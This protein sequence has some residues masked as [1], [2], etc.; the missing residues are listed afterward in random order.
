M[1]TV[2]VLFENSLNKGIITDDV[3]KIFGRAIRDA[4]QKNGLEITNEYVGLRKDGNKMYL[5]IYT[6]NHESINKLLPL[7]EMFFNFHKKSD[8]TIKNSSEVFKRRIGQILFRMYEIGRLKKENGKVVTL[9]QG[10]KILENE[11]YK[12]IDNWQISVDNSTLDGIDFDDRVKYRKNINR[13][14]ANQWIK[15]SNNGFDY[16]LGKSI[17]LMKLDGDKYII[18]NGEK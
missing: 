14:V 4:V 11:L 13:L 6:Q 9:E 2:E 15:N 8:Y 1:K 5:G 7:K 18:G 12:D 3:S 10:L 17:V 16:K